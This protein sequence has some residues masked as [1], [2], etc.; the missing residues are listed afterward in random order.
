MKSEKERSA[1][2][3]KWVVELTK[4]KDISNE[5]ALNIVIGVVFKAV[6]S[7]AIPSSKESHTVWAQKIMDL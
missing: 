2:L 1:Q 4:P 6:Y 5:R 7:K 3:A